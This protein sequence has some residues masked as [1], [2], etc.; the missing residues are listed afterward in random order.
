[1]HVGGNIKLNAYDNTGGGG[2]YNTSSGLIIGN[3]YDA[4]K[5]YSGSDDRTAC[6]WQERGLDLDFATNNA[7]RMKLTYE[8]KLLIGHT[9]V[10]S[11]AGTSP[12]QV[13]AATSGAWAAQFR[14]RSNNDYTF[15][16]F[17]NVSGSEDLAQIG[18]QRVTAS[19]GRQCHSGQTMAVMVQASGCVST[20][21]E[22]SASTIPRPVI[23]Q[24]M[25]E[26]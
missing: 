12:L 16:D 13:T 2:G 5:S 24:A 25:E 14:C 7:V 20:A 10:G 18:A 23:T 1:M 22:T 26:I 21:L 6:I 3:L 4:G 8:G 15:L 11:V 17:A 19:T 9:S